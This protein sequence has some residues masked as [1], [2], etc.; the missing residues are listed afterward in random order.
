MNGLFNSLRLFVELNW[1][2]FHMVG[3]LK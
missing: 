3:T 1:F 2:E